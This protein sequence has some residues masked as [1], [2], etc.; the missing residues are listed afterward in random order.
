MKVDAS[1][2]EVLAGGSAALGAAL[3]GGC[4]QTPVAGTLDGADWRRGHLLRDGGFPEP[5]GPVEEVDVVIA[6]GG[7]AGL[8]TGWR[9]AEAGFA[10]FT[11]FELEDRT[12]GNARSGRNSV[13][14]YPLGAHYLPVPNREAG[15]LRQMLRGFGIITGDGAAGPVYDPYQ[16]CADLEERLLWRG[17][18][19]EGLFPQTGLAS[20]ERADYKA[21][22]DAMASFRVAIG[23]DGRPAFAIPM[24]LSSRDPRFTALDGLTFAAWLDARELTAPALRAYLRYCCRD[25]YGAEPEHVSA[26]AGIHY[27]A[28]RRGWAANGDGDRE[29]TWP[30]GNDRLATLMARRISSQLRPA[31][32]VFRVVRSPDGNTAEVDVHDHANARSRRLRAKVVIMAMPHFVASRIAPELCDAGAFSYAP[33]VVANVTVSRHPEGKGVSLA[34]D[35]VSTA[36]NSLGYVVAT[37]QSASDPTGPTVLTWYY[38][39]SKEAPQT[40]RKIMLTR[41]LEQWQALVLRDLMG[42]NPDL[43]G[44]IERID[45]W[46]WGH[47][48][49]RPTPGFLTDP[50]RQRARESQ[51]PVLFAHSDLSGLSLFEEAHYRGVTAGE[52]TLSHLGLAYER[53]A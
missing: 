37:H 32:S 26:W 48:M 40:A 4:A 30:E 42:M 3:L 50:A 11:L 5:E 12:G 22:E 28:A 2:R 45:V 44:A 17:Q 49:I 53:L 29:L 52:R 41:S 36:S 15:A 47:A 1:R 13:S 25:D 21:F 38:P 14:A 31:H 6:G 46:R 51:P 43:E 16:L 7:I 10:N 33:W 27:F 18:W 19:Q 23:N 20:P 39:M 24:A 35:N 34:W 8:A 9:L